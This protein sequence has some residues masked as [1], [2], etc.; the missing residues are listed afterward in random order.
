MV[1]KKVYKAQD[2]DE[3][4]MARFKEHSKLMNQK[5]KAISEKYRKWWDKDKKTWKEGFKGHG[6]S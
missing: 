3:D 5:S 1:K 6:H 4:E 2:I